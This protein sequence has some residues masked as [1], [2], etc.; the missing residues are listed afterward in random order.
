MLFYIL[1]LYVS[2]VGLMNDYTLSKHPTRLPWYVLIIFNIISSI[3]RYCYIRTLLG[4]KSCRVIEDNFVQEGIPFLRRRINSYESLVA[5][6]PHL[7]VFH[8]SAPEETQSWK[9]LCSTASA[10]VYTT[11]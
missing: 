11:R 1:F 6:P 3:A 2:S 5:S 9:S 10:P 7:F 8:F 4:K